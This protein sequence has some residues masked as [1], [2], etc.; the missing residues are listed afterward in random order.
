MAVVVFVLVAAWRIDHPDTRLFLDVAVGVFLLAMLSDVLDGWAARRFHS[1]SA[2]GRI[3]DAFT[4]KILVCGTFAFLAGGNFI[5]DRDGAAATLT[6]IAPWMVVVLFSREF[7]VNAIR[8][9]SESLGRPFPATVYGKAKM[10]LQCVTIIY[11]LLHVG[12][13]RHEAPWAAAMRD[14]LVWATVT[15]TALSA[16]VYVGR[17]WRLIRMT[18]GDSLAGTTD[19]FQAP[20]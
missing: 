8:G 14:T 5:A 11:I 15:V 19:S 2:L 7:L 6:G 20:E 1:S 16:L 10:S 13:L 12:H 3:A 9:W 17:T 4:D 18:A